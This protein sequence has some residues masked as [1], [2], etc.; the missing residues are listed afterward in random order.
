[1]LLYIHIKN[2]FIFAFYI[3]IYI[4]RQGYRKEIRVLLPFN[5]IYEKNNDKR[6]GYSL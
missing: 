1:M 3:K 6:V 5:V 4:N 2:M